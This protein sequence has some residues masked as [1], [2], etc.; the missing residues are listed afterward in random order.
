MPTPRFPQ[1]RTLTR[2]GRSTVTKV[3]STAQHL[4][5]RLTDRPLV[6][7]FAALL[8][9][10]LW[11]RSDLQHR[12]PERCSLDGVTL[13]RTARV[14]LVR[15]DDELARFCG[16]TCA[17]SWPDVPDGAW[18]RV[19][20]EATGDR[21]A[22]SEAIFVT[23]RVVNAR[24]R[25]DHVHAFARLRDALAHADAFRGRVIPC[26][27]PPIDALAAERAVAPHLDLRAPS[28]DGQR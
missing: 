8:G 20:D 2:S 3:S 4:T 15:G 9:L 11:S 1:A 7:W 19:G 16:T 5:G 25:Q 10:G 21:I 18:W 28:Q 14:D 22:A 27:L 23:S 26:P 24:A 12:G 13:S 6:L 17:A